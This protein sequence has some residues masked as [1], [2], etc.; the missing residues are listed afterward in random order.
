MKK[1]TLKKLTLTYYKGVKNFVLTPNVDITDIFGDNKTGKSTLVN[2]VLWLVWGKDQF[3]RKDYQIK[4]LDINNKPIHKIEHIVEGVLDIDGVEVELKRIY[5]EKWTKRRNSQE[6]IMDGHDTLLFIDDVPMRLHEFN[7]KIQELIGD[8]I[9]FKLLTNPLF[10]N[11]EKGMSKQLGFNKDKIGWKNRR[12]LL[13]LIVGCED[14]NTIINKNED[15]KALFD[16]IGGKSFADHLKSVKYKKTKIEEEKKTIPVRIDEQ[17]KSKPELV[18]FADLEKQKISIQERIDK[19]DEKIADKSKAT[20]DFQENK[21]KLIREKGALQI[22]LE[23]IESELKNEIKIK[24][25]AVRVEKWGNKKDI[26]GCEFF[27]KSHQQKIDFNNKEI[28]RWEVKVGQLRGEID[29]LNK[30]GFL[31]DESLALCPTC[32]R[33]IDN[34]EDKKAELEANY[35]KDKANKGAFIIKQGK[36]INKKIASVRV[37]SALLEDKIKEEQAKI[38][39]IPTVVSDKIPTI[40]ELLTANKDYNRLKKQIDEFVIDENEPVV[41][42]FALVEEKNGLI[43]DLENINKQLGIKGEIEKAD[44]RIVEL[45]EEEKEKAQLLADLEKDEYIIKQFNETKIKL[46]ETPINNLFSEHINFKL[47]EKQIN[48][49]INDCCECLVNGVPFMGANNGAQIQTG[50]EI[51]NVLQKHFEVTLPILV[52]NCEAVTSLPKTD[53]QLIRLYVSKED[54]TLRVV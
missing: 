52:D 3:D 10:F 42:D 27:I 30:E 19:I 29:S 23:K 11:D 16:R 20:L 53:A 47:F 28:E 38:D 26:E 5:K 21:Q 13:M 18:D 40:A 6:L 34:V 22:E 8:E 41:V 54:K 7:T 17:V 49:E 31:F 33:E 32:K 50:I 35:N 37:E 48:G 51:I 2:S 9:L 4:T 44:L 43:L 25:D 14:D 12:N 24:E 46:V 15:F 1:I 39:D 45:E 36:E